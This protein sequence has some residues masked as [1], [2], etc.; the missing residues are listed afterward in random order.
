[1]SLEPDADLK[2]SLEKKLADQQNPPI[3]TFSGKAP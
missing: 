2:I 1:M 3:A